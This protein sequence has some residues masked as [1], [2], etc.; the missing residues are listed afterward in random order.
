[1]T[2]RAISPRKPV[3]IR[4]P[5]DPN[6]P[7]AIDQAVSRALRENLERIQRTTDELHQAVSDVVSACASSRPTNALPSMLRAQTAAASIS[8]ALA[9]F[10]YS[11]SNVGKF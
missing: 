8:A 4:M 6:P 11:A 10:A 1:M 7:S 9:R 3:N 2:K 5:Q